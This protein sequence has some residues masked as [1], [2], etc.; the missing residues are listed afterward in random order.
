MFEIILICRFVE[1]CKFFSDSVS[2]VFGAIST[3]V[4]AF[5]LRPL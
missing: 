1:I 2:K 4:E 3:A 5:Y